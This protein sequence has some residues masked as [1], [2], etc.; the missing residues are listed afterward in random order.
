MTAAPGRRLGRRLRLTVL[1]ATALLTSTFTGQPMAFS[2]ERDPVVFVHGYNGGSSNWNDMIADFKADGY[3]TAQLNAWDYD[4]TQSNKVIAEQ[5]ATYVDGVLA[6]TGATKVD[7]IGHSMG[8]LNSRWFAKFI[9]GTA[10]IDDYVSLGSPHHG[11]DWA[12]GCA[13][14]SCTEMRP[15]SAFL[16][17]LNAGDE[18]PGTVKYG[19]WWSPCDEVIDPKESPILSGATNVQTDCLGHLALLTDNTVSQQVRTFVA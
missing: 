1:V 3:T 18:T 17:E 2:A 13:D 11:T 6:R 15:G 14:I 19:S 4:H 10:E 7:I 5:L 12:Y 9:G 8:G 16:G